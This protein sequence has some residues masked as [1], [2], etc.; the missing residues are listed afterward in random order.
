MV[1]WRS[2]FGLL[3]QGEGPISQ[4]MRVVWLYMRSC[5]PSSDAEVPENAERA[6][7]REGERLAARYLQRHGCKVL[8][9]NFRGPSGGEVDIVCRDKSCDTLVFVEVKTRRSLAMGRPA[10]AVTPQKQKLLSRGA[11]QWLQLLKKRDVPIRFDIVEVLVAD[12][13][14]PQCN[15]IRNAFTLAEPYR[16]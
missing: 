8:Y 6:L 13:D 3:R 9:R 2:V 12:G 14:E 11:M 10:E 4:R 16:Y 1:N 15:H 7:G 5:L